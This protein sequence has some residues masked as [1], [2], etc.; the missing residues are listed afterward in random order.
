[1]EIERTSTISFI[2]KQLVRFYN[3]QS[4]DLNKLSI[5]SA[6]YF[7]ILTANTFGTNASTSLFMKMKGISDLPLMYIFTSLVV[8]FSIISY[9]IFIDRL[10]KRKLLQFLIISV[11]SL[12]LLSR[13]ILVFQP[14]WFYSLLYVGAQAAWLILYTQFWSLANEI[15]DLRQAKRLF[16]LIIGSGLLGGIFAGFLSAYVVKFIHTEN[17]LILWALALIGVYFL[18]IKINSSDIDTI[19]NEHKLPATLKT[20]VTDVFLGAKFVFNSNYLKSI[21]LSFFLYGLAVYFL[22]FQ[23]NWIVNDTFKEIDKLTA[24]YGYYS[25]IFYFCTFILQMFAV[26][27]ILSQF[28]VGNVLLIF[29]A[30]LLSGFSALFVSFKFIPAV[31][32]K[33]TRDVVG[34]SLVETAYP[35]LYNPVEQKMRGR[36][37]SFVEGVIIPLGIGSAGIILY[38]IQ[39]FVSMKYQTAWLTILGLALTAIWLILSLNLRKEYVKVLLDS[40]RDTSFDVRYLTIKAIDEMKNDQAQKVLIRALQD[41]DEDLRIFAIEMIEKL[42][43][44]TAIPNLVEVLETDKSSRV[45]ATTIETLG[46]FISKNIYDILIK[47]L[48]DKDDRVRANTVEAIGKMG[49]TEGCDLLS[50]KIDDGNVRVK[51]NAC[52]ALHKLGDDRGLEYLLSLLK[53]TNPE[54]RSSA[55]YA[56]GQMVKE[57]PDILTLALNDTAPRVR[58]NSLRGLPHDIS[59]DIIEFLGKALDDPAPMVH[60]YA[61][62]RLIRTGGQRA[63]DLLSSRLKISNLKSQ[64]TAIEGLGAMHDPR[65][66]QLLIQFLDS[67]HERIREAVINVLDSIETKEER[68]KCV[69]CLKSE[70]L[71]IYYNIFVTKTLHSLLKQT[72]QLQVL[73]EAL[74][75]KIL[76]TKKLIFKIIGLLEG[77]HHGDKFLRWQDSDSRR[78]AYVL[79]FLEETGDKYIS[80]YTLPLLEDTDP[81]KLQSLTNELFARQNIDLIEC[82]KT[83]STNSEEWVRACVAY[84]LQFLINTS[85]TEIVINM[86]DDESK[87]VRENA[88]IALEILEKQAPQIVNKIRW[89]EIMLKRL[90]NG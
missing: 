25:G 20:M 75:D 10:D 53:N 89:A 6:I 14:S 16:P 9:S 27:K 23:Y 76:R 79:E 26:N 65:A 82:F 80:Q 64:I 68:S 46:S 37:I 87:L 19:S 50:R 15:C 69:E 66:K 33:L 41:D 22:D 38:L 57:R 63:F 1:M 7:C 32:A 29:P 35:L 34:N 24:F 21:S 45:R 48:D 55:A 90:K 36:T 88:E 62:E 61:R 59:D 83:L 86:L 49:I 13:V 4:D 28:G 52:I 31:Y 39:N 84:V 71:S 30:I 77:F 12:I 74:A 11:T 56:A 78:R 67:P 18:S 3:L 2:F 81:M 40:L 44:S 47:Y 43:L 73:I 17:L 85:N 72:P 8:S 51:I 42:R 54:I 70:T 60:R 5:L 58:L